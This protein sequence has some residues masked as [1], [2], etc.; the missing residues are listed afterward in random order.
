MRCEKVRERLSAFLDGE[1]KE[2]EYR[3]IASHLESCDSCSHDC[4]ELRR[5]RELLSHLGTVQSPPYLWERV[6]RKI[7][8]QERTNLWERLSHR[9]VYAPVGVAILIGLLI[10]NYLGQNMSQQSVLTESELLSLNTLDDFPPGS[11]SDAY[12]GGWEE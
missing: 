4:E 8:S 9:L 10:G 7:S 11:L 3:R 1:L 12:F 5:L 6:E 2:D